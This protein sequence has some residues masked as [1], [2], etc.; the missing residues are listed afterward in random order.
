MRSSVMRAGRPMKSRAGEVGRY[1]PLRIND[2]RR[3]PR[4][5]VT[6]V[7]IPIRVDM[8][9]GRASQ[10]CEVHLGR[11]VIQRSVQFRGQRINARL[12]DRMD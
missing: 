7:M 4:A 12:T 10:Q 11:D 5:F 3:V 2:R 8:Q 6:V 1:A 9:S